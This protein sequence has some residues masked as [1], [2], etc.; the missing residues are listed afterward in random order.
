[1]YYFQWHNREDQQKISNAPNRSP[2]DSNTATQVSNAPSSCGTDAFL[3]KISSALLCSSPLLNNDNQDTQFLDRPHI[4]IYTIQ[5]WLSFPWSL[6]RF[7]QHK[8]KHYQELLP[9]LSYELSLRIPCRNRLNKCN[10]DYKY[11][12]GSLWLVDLDSKKT[13]FTRNWKERTRR[14]SLR[15]SHRRKGV[16]GSK[17]HSRITLFNR[18]LGKDG[19]VLYLHCLIQ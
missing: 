9:A 13:D 14:S 10:V 3:A 8:P 2:E 12:R 18:T 17:E 5:N 19:N 11:V 7:I 4:S 6:L 15:K 16:E 1:M